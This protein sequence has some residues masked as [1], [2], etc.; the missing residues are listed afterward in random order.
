MKKLTLLIIPLLLLSV[1]LAS[2]GKG[3]WATDGL[4]PKAEAIWNTNLFEWD[5]DDDGYGDGF[6]VAIGWNPLVSDGD[7][8]G[9]DNDEDVLSNEAET[10]EYGTNPNLWDTDNDGVGDSIEIIRET[11]PLSADYGYGGADSDN[12]R[13]SDAF[14]INVLGTDELNWD[15]DDDHFSDSNE[16]AAGTDP[17]DKED[18]PTP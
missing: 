1:G 4:G 8:S 5:T 12:D 18:Y 16:Y 2:N 7:Y 6:E 17:F 15:T 13:L 9:T 14:E 11:D 3:P 10:E